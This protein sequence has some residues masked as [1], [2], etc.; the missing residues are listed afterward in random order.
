MA[1]RRERNE[2]SYERFNVDFSA[3]C[4]HMSARSARALLVLLLP[5]NLF[6]LAT[7]QNLY[8]LVKTVQIRLKIRNFKTKVSS[9]PCILDYPHV[10]L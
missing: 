7:G 6:R 2:R 4:A 8:F 9:G 5:I 3:R 1:A 10:G